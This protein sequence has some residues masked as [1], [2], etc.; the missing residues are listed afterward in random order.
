MSKKS[1][2]VTATAKPQQAAQAAK[3]AS[4]FFEGVEDVRGDSVYLPRT[5]GKY[6]LKITAM[7]R[8]VSKKNGKDYMLAEFKVIESTNPELSVKSPPVTYYISKDPLWPNVA[9]RDAK[10]FI[11]GVGEV[12]EAEITAGHCN[13]IFDEQLFVGKVVNLVTTE[14][15]TV[16]SKKTVPVYAWSV[17]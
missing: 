5:P 15:V 10:N 16:K 3:G 13:Q 9:L 6:K 1:N 2:N 14:R 11:A 8:G 7:K 4:M 12:D 17:A